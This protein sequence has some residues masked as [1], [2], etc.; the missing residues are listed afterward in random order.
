[1]HRCDTHMK[2]RNVQILN[3][4]HVKFVVDTKDEDIQGKE[5]MDVSGEEMDVSEYV[6]PGSPKTPGPQ[7]EL[8]PPHIT[9]YGVFSI[10]FMIV[11]YS[12]YGS[13][14]HICCY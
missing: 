14:S 11:C 2:Y 3:C 4:L 5:H 13:V 12:L 10:G 1:M 9:R 7:H 8:S 6:Q